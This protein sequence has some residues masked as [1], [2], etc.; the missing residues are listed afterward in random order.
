MYIVNYATDF[1][2]QFIALIHVLVCYSALTQKGLLGGVGTLKRKQHLRELVDNHNKDQHDDV[3][4]APPLEKRAK[5]NNVRTVNHVCL[6]AYN[7]HYLTA[8]FSV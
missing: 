1:L 4:D 5:L 7:G 6:N 2:L 8:G 3:L